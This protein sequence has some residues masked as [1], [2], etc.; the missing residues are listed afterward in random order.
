M[1]EGVCT[2]A[3]VVRVTHMSTRLGNGGS[4]VVDARF[5]WQGQSYHA[6]SG[7]LP[8]RP[9]CEAGQTVTVHFMPNHPSDNRILNGDAPPRQMEIGRSL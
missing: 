1:R 9:L 7:L 3:T 6:M 5:T 4:Y 8:Y 2:D